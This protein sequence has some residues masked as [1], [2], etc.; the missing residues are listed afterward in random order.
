MRIVIY[1]DSPEFLYPLTNFLPQFRLRIGMKTIAEHTA[2]V[3]KSAQMNF[4]G[5]PIFGMKM[6]R[7][8]ECTVYLSARLLLNKH[9]TVPLAD[10][11]LRVGTDNVGFV[12]YG[13]P[14]P[15]SAAEIKATFMKMKKIRQVHGLL[16][17]N[18]W[19]LIACNEKLTAFHFSMQRKKSRV[20]KGVYVNGS[21]K[22]LFIAQD[23]EIHNYVFLDVSQ[24]PIHIDRGAKIR[25]FTSI[26]GPAYIGKD[27]ELDRA[28]IVK[29]S[30]GPGC[31]IGGEVE[32]CVFQGYSNKYHEGFIGHSFVGEWVNLGALTTNSDLKNNYGPVRLR[33]G[34]REVDSG[35][36]K[37]GCFIGDH[38]KL[39]IGTLIPT[40]A[41]IGSFVNFAGGGMM[42]RFVP[43]FRWLTT[44]KEE[45]YDL[46][47]AISTAKVVMKRRGVKMSKQYEIMIRTMHGQIRR[48]D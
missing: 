19:D 12:K 47:K 18:L 2:L 16:I 28:K 27:T 10:S 32:A 15:V 23:A 35:Q 33:I 45:K 5:R 42:P 46:G 24:G 31:R 41:V 26:I 9:F 22:D 11:L 39:G 3:C 8:K 17:S 29:S 4:V 21:R 1:E 13:A 36:M 14:F 48:S 7:P 6:A 40:G 43:S 44:G 37:L 25:P 20:L 38:T 30:I 34:R